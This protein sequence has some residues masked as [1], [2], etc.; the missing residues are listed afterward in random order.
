MSENNRTIRD[1]ATSLSLRGPDDLVSELPGLLGYHP[2][3]SLVAVLTYEQTLR[4]VV[5]MDLTDLDAQ[6]AIRI[7]SVAHQGEADT[8]HVVI[9]SE[10]TGEDL[11][12]HGQVETMCELLEEAG[13]H[14]SDV[15]LVDEGRYWSYLCQDLR[16]CPPEG[17]PVREGTSVLEAERVRAGQPAVAPTR[18]VAARTYRLRPEMEPT[19]G[20][21]RTARMLL[22]RTIQDRGRVACE[23]VRSLIALDE[24]GQLGLDSNDD[25]LDDT[26]R[27]VVVTLLQDIQVRDL[28]LGTLAASPGPLTNAAQVLIRTTVSAP[29]VMRPRV[30]ATAAAL[31]A[32]DGSNPVA[33]W[34][35]VDLAGDESL[36]ALVKAGTEQGIPP[37]MVR[38]TFAEAL[39]LVLERV[40]AS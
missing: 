17:R 9:Y 38:D 16:C 26:L 33:L 15:I 39:P 35:M 23:A 24:D 19:S 1:T 25:Q 30:A 5:R 14:V 36:A 2:A 27:A 40:T 20:S 18:E 8:I 22:S 4:C 29:R 12:R 13:V 32:A 34:A 11:P 7:I 37:G 28:F 10:F 31:L 6:A 21:L 3:D